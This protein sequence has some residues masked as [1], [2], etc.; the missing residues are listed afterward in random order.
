M[1]ASG[2]QLLPDWTVFVQLGI[3]L[4]VAVALNALVF[5]PVFRIMALRRERTK[6]EMEKIEKLKQKTEAMLVEYEKKLQ[7]AKREAFQ[8]KEAIRKE[9]EA[10]AQ[11]LLQEARSAGRTEL[12]QVKKE[13]EA[14]V[15]QAR[16][17]LQGEA[18]NLS[19]MM[20]E[21]ILRN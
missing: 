21:K 14:S 3:F 2:V 17:K 18:A 12:E 8:M 4:L 19:E 10:Q 9:G 16:Q 11:Q 6:G 1:L 13:L 15:D 7:G 20:V 5:R